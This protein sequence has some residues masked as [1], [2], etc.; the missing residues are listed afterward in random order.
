MPYM[1]ALHLFIERLQLAPCEMVEASFN[2]LSLRKLTDHRAVW[3]NMNG[4]EPSIVKHISHT[5]TSIDLIIHHLNNYSQYHAMLM[6][7]QLWI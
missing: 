6:Y 4:G 1:Q 2:M 5:Y 3:L 7:D